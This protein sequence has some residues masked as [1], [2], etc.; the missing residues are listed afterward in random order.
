[1]SDKTGIIDYGAGNIFSLKA[2]LDRVGAAYE[3]VQDPAQLPDYARIIIPGVGHAGAA[4]QR[5]IDSGMSSHIES[6][7]VPVL[8]ICVGMQLLTQYSEEGSSDLLGILPLDTL[9][10]ARRTAHKV[11]HMGWNQVHFD[12]NTPL[13]E[14]V[15][16]DAYFYFVH[17]YFVPYDARWTTA[18]TD[19]GLRFAASVRRG[20]FYGVQFHP[21]KSGKPG[22]RLLWNF[23]QMNS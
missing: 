14:E 5:L 16:K 23:T 11:P 9:H 8:G 2:A 12:E 6:L 22:E 18:Y 3:L 7:K 19:Y 17:S 10:F 4:M 13:F 15:N 20:H 21:E 1:M